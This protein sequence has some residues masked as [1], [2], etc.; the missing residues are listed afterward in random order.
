MAEP[1]LPRPSLVRLQPMDEEEGVR[2]IGPAQS[3]APPAGEPAP[4]AAPTPAPALGEDGGD[5][6]EDLFARLRAERMAAVSR[7][8]EV[9]A[10][11]AA[12]AAAHTPAEEALPPASASVETEPPSEAPPADDT[13]RTAPAEQSERGPVPAP[14]AAHGDHGLMASMSKSSRRERGP[15]SWL[16]ASGAVVPSLT[17]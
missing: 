16:L 15:S 3:P 8:E 12:P 5:S 11:E 9:L 4:A 13:E 17:R 7:A 6:V 14:V 1:D 10:T 2:I